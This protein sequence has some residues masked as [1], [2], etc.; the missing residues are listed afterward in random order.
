MPFALLMD[1]DP[2]GQ[3]PGRHLPRPAPRA[4]LPHMKQ[5]TERDV[6]R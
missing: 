1:A 4:I 3:S 2:E 6:V 5:A